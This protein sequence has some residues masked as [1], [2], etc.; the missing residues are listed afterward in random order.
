M[1]RLL[2]VFQAERPR[3]TDAGLPPDWGDR[4]AA[5]LK[6]LE[7][8]SRPDSIHALTDLAGQLY[9][10]SDT[11]FS[12]QEATERGVR[13]GVIA[14]D[15]SN[16]TVPVEGRGDPGAPPV[17]G[18]QE[19]APTPP[20]GA[21]PASPLIERLADQIT[22]AALM[23]KRGSSEQARNDSTL[24]VGNAE[25]DLAGEGETL[26]PT[27]ID[28]YK[29]LD[30]NAFVFNC[31][32]L[33][34][35]KCGKWKTLEYSEDTE[36]KVVKVEWR[37]T[38]TVDSNNPNI[39]RVKIWRDTTYKIKQRHVV[40]NYK[41]CCCYWDI[42][43]FDA[44]FPFDCA[45]MYKKMDDT[46][47]ESEQVIPTLFDEDDYVNWGQEIWALIKNLLNSAAGTAGGALGGTIKGPAEAVGGALGKEIEKKLKEKLGLPVE[48]DK[49][50]TPAPPAGGGAAPGAGGHN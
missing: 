39:T 32:G 2:G 43:P 24:K 26:H 19:P 28:G 9:A 45:A 15:N 16:P 3:F 8:E 48:P 33:S 31:H 49:P 7:A 6:V 1:S 14:R 34:T 5:H 4:V 41:V 17:A 12:P 27:T 23:G 25:V 42:L 38:E 47:K 37:H 10:V 40:W 30:D 13:G 44:R 36:R 29:A 21:Q 35:R 46:T 11:V 18:G 22:D 50:A 20:T